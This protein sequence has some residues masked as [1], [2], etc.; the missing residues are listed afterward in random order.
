M[1]RWE[2]V[3]KS[4]SWFFNAP[5]AQIGKRL[6]I[7]YLLVLGFLVVFAT[8][9]SSWPKLNELGDFLAG[10]FA[11]IA[12]LWLVLGFFQQ[13]RELRNSARS[14]ELQGQALKNQVK[15]LN[16][17]VEQSRLLAKAAQE[18]LE[19][20]RRL[21]H[22]KMEEDKAQQLPMLIAEASIHHTEH[23]YSTILFTLSNE[24]G[25]ITEVNIMY[26]DFLRKKQRAFFS[27]IHR[28]GTENALLEK[29]PDNARTLIQV[30]YRDSLGKVRK[31][32]WPCG[33]SY[34]DGEVQVALPRRPL[35]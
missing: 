31:D 7:A 23:N 2:L 21:F 1:P 30:T 4:E 6:S 5:L 27:R 26:E 8:D 25:E 20:D 15:E 34:A 32:T 11:P 24:G 18:Q 12:L 33:L 13:G 14:L 19:L 16:A 22:A 10:A 35:G 9:K 28:D 29:I 3:E 17:S